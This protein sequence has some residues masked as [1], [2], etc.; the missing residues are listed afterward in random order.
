[1]LDKPHT[2]EQLA[3]LSAATETSD[4]LM[5]NALA[6][7]GKTSTLKLVERAV[8][9]KPILYLVFNKNAYLALWLRGNGKNYG[10]GNG[11]RTRS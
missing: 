11:L 4:N 10:D 3:I 2:D 6:G 5:L 7:T 9:A 1:M 8:K